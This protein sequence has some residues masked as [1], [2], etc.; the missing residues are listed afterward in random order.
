MWLGGYIGQVG[1]NMLSLFAHWQ[2]DMRVLTYRS[3]VLHI[4]KILR[5]FIYYCIVYIQV[6]SPWFYVYHFCAGA[7][8]CKKC[9]ITGA[10]YIG[11]LLAAMYVVDANPGPL[12]EQHML[13]TNEPAPRPLYVKFLDSNTFLMGLCF[14]ITSNVHVFPKS[15]F[16]TVS[17]ILVWLTQWPLT[18][19]VM[20]ISK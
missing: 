4:C 11:C 13:L 17:V 20:I 14:V 6:P 1:L 3:M 7:S 19:S 8:I 5:R 12:Q 10:W 9:Q 16:C 18:T 2:M 15:S